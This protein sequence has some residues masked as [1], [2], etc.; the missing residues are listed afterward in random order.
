MTL[1]PGNKIPSAFEETELISIYPY[2]LIIKNK[3]N[4]G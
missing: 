2:S 3:I 4:K 1:V